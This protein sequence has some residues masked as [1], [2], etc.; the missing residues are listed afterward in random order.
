LFPVRP[1]RS[2]NKYPTFISRSRR[3]LEPGFQLSRERPD[4]CDSPALW[5][6]PPAAFMGHIPVEYTWRSIVLFS[7]VLD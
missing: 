1:H 6:A 3:N 4:D 5:V 2:S 7:Y